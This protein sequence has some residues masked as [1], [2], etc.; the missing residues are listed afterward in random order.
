MDWPIGSGVLQSFPE[1]DRAAWFTVQS[2]KE[3]LFEGQVG[4]VV[5]LEHQIEKLEMQKP[6][7]VSDELKGSIGT[8]TSKVLPSIVSEGRVHQIES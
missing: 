6:P 7:S 4:F 5:E 1:V 3:K 8:L 2:A